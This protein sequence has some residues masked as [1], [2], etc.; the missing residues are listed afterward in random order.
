[1][2]SKLNNAAIAASMWYMQVAHH[3]CL[4]T[5]VKRP[6]SQT[7][8]KLYSNDNRAQAQKQLQVC[9]LSVNGNSTLAQ[10]Q[11]AACLAPVVTVLRHNFEHAS[12]LSVAIALWR[13][14]NVQHNVHQ[15]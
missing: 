1:M 14:H 15:W 7:G 10:P 11:L 3:A 4:D 8:S 6:P 13:S 12:C 5:S 2:H 9:R